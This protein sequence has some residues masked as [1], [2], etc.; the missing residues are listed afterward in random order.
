MR[1]VSQKRAFV[2]FYVRT[3][4][5][6]ANTTAV[7]TASRGD[8][9]VTLMPLNEG[10]V[11]QLVAN[12]TRL[13]RDQPCPFPIAGRIPA[14]RRVSASRGESDHPTRTSRDPE[15]TDCSNNVAS[16]DVRFEDLPPLYLVIYSIA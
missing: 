4:Q 8:S 13:V 9:S 2:R 16:L 12:P 11:I 7:L 14:G 3:S 1:L 5:G 15:E 6:T 10:A